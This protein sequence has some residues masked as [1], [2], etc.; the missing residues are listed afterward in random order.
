MMINMNIYK[1][2]LV[3]LLFF[4]FSGCDAEDIV[5][6]PIPTPV[7]QNSSIEDFIHSIYVNYYEGGP[8]INI[9][10]PETDILL[11]PSLLQ[12]MHHDNELVQGEAGFLDADPIC[13][14]QDYGNIKVTEIAVKKINTSKSTAKVSFINFERP[15]IV[16]F[17]LLKIN[18]LWHIDDIS[19]ADM[20][21]MR[22]GLEREIKELSS[23]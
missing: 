1:Y 14:C 15:T 6:R 10:G 16:E 11:S 2:L 22:A 3:T 13:E 9:G 19:S 18:G 7:K 20:P 5:L 21:S 4:I 8:G 12:I 17:S 23:K